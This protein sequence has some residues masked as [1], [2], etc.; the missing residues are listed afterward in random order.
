MIGQQ[1]TG[2]VPGVVITSVVHE[3]LRVLVNGRPAR[4]AIVDESGAIVAEGD[5]VARE[6]EAVAINQYRQTMRGLGHLRVWGEDIHP[7]K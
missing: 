4:L 2:A 5:R 7:R 6:A 3:G 1:P